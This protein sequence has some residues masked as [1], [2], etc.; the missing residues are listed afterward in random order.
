MSDFISLIPFGKY[1]YIV[2]INYAVV[3]WS[4]W[5]SIQLYFQID[6]IPYVDN[7][8]LWTL[9]YISTYN[10]ISNSVSGAD[11]TLFQLTPQFNFLLR[12]T[13]CNLWN[14]WL[15]F[16]FGPRPPTQ[17]QRT[18]RNLE[19]ERRQTLTINQLHTKNVIF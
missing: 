5:W 3:L 2:I 12:C 7:W 1:G 14:P 13:Q 19:L 9:V 10:H 17:G 8:T 16:Q 15:Y 6:P 18:L 11:S 4:N